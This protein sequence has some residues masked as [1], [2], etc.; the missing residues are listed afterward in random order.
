MSDIERSFRKSRRDFRKAM[1]EWSGIVSSGNYSLEELGNLKKDIDLLFVLFMKEGK[2][3]I[4][5]KEDQFEIENL[6]E[7]LETFSQIYQTLIR[8]F[9]SL[10]DKSSLK[11]IELVL[12]QQ[13]HQVLE[14]LNKFSSQISNLESRIE[15]IEFSS[16]DISRKE[17]PFNPKP[18]LNPQAK[19]FSQFS[20]IPYTSKNIPPVATK[21]DPQNQYLDEAGFILR[22]GLTSD[23]KFKF[24]GE[25]LNYVE[26]I[27]HFNTCYVKKISD[28]D[29]LSVCLI[30]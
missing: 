4:E 25:P 13:N 2:E 16:K 10:N 15:S 23:R 6:K 29:V 18:E 24:N 27:R 12:D 30:C 1:D 5:E 26:F 14:R 9:D 22:H 11:S 20:S 17:T 3:L 28:P 21:H 8:E 7:N 19:E